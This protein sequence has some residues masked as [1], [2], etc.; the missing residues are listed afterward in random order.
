MNRDEKSALFRFVTIYTL[1]SIILIAIIAYLYYE[2]EIDRQKHLCQNDLQMGVIRV[3][4]KLLKAKLNH[5]PFL[6]EPNDFKGGVGLFDDAHNIVHSSLHYEQVNFKAIITKNPNYIHF[7]HRL[8][9]P[10]LGIH[11]I[12]TEDTSMPI[13]KEKLLTLIMIVIFVS[14]LFIAFIGY[15]LSK[16]LLKPVK[17]KMQHLDK[18]I[19]D[20]AHEINTPIAALLMSVSALKKKGSADAKILKH[21]AISSKQISDVYNSLSHLAFDDVQ[22]QRQIETIDFQRIVQK[23]IDFYSQ[24]ADSREMSILANLE[25]TV[26]MIDKNDAQ[27]LINNL[28][29]NAVKYNRIGKEIEISL[30]NNVL[31]VIDQGIGIERE[32]KVA[33]L[34]RYHR[35]NNPQGGFGIGL[36]IVNSISKRYHIILSIESHKGL[37]SRFSL[38]FAAIALKT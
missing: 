10:L 28:L 32:E 11:Y 9:H 3:E 7:V 15:L 13:S 29:S 33:I 19:K 34:K 31:T 38:D 5:Q 24:L 2:K 35:G 26:I 27:K 12:V 22:V 17:E 6:F 25:K 16:I 8:E 20:S 14:L 30:Y 36:D 23:S 18:F 21:I 1:S 37:G 4:A